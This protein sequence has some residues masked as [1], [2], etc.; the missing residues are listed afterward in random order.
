M[1]TTGA[2]DS[3][4]GVVTA[5]AG[6]TALLLD[7]RHLDAGRLAAMLAE[8]RTLADEAAEAEKCTRRVGAALAHRA[9]PV[10]PRPDRRG[11]PRLPG[12][13]GQRSRAASGPLHD[14]AEMA[15]HVPTV[16]LFSSS[17][18]GISHAKEED[19]PIEH[20]E[21]AIRA[22]AQTVGAAIDLVVRLGRLGSASRPRSRP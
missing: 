18:N 4:P 5:I 16:M 2:A 7:Q 10:R 21:L 14:A 9:D 11:A 6:E 1:S 12:G 3:Q 20:L 17:T 15:R 19:T 8:S 13:R 22:Y